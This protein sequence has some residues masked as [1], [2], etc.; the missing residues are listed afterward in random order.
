MEKKKVGIIL[1]KGIISK[2]HSNI[3]CLNCLQSFTTK[4]KLESHERVFKRK[5]FFGIVL[6]TQKNIYI[7]I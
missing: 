3:Y 5:D 4:N 2:Q 6:P 1:W 7:R